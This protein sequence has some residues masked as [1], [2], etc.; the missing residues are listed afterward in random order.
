MISP[1]SSADEISGGKITPD[2]AILKGA[3][4]PTNKQVIRWMK[5]H[6]QFKSKINGIVRKQF[7][8]K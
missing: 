7:W 8:N 5:Y 4:L 1:R 3:K 6:Q 2:D